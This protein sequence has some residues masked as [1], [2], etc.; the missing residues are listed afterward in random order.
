MPITL[1]NPEGLPEIDVYH[2]V[3]VATG[4]K[5]IYVAGQVAWDAE[6]DLTTQTQQA[7]GSVHTALKAAG[8][9]LKDLVKITVYVVDW[10]PDKMP[11]LLKGIENAMSAVGETAKPPATLIGVAA[12]DVPEHLVEI[13]A[14]AVI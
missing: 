13:E 4:T 3:A 2:Q 11:E 9:S 7:Y 6:P 5:T 10:T 8:A 1:I 12:L 14:V